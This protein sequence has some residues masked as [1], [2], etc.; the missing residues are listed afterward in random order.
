MVYGRLNFVISVGRTLT[1]RA[2]LISLGLCQLTG[3][4]AG[5]SATGFRIRMEPND[6]IPDQIKY[7]IIRSDLIEFLPKT[8]IRIRF[9]V[10][11]RIRNTVGHNLV[12]IG[13]V[14]MMENTTVFMIDLSSLYFIVSLTVLYEVACPHLFFSSGIFHRLFIKFWKSTIS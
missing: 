11:Y 4:A 2:P 6:D 10:I 12:R 9:N 7:D 3:G 5:Q 13:L 14:N 1:F 8:W